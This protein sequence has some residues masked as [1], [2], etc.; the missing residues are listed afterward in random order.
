MRI[1]SIVSLGMLGMGCMLQPALAA[2][3]KVDNVSSLHAALDKARVDKRITRIELATGTYSLPAPIVFDEGLSGT[4]AMPFV[5]APVRGAHPVLSGAEN[6]PSLSWEAGKG[7]VW[8]ARV[9]D[10]DFQRLWLGT[11]ML[12]RARY[13][14][15]DPAIRTFGGVAADATSKE[16]V[17]SWR[18]PA[19]AVLHALHGGRW[20][21]VHVP[22]LGKNPDG[23]LRFGAQ[24]ANNRIAPPSGNARFVENILEEL[25]APG[26]WFHDRSGGW[27]YYKPLD[28][29]RPPSLGFR[30]GRLE[31]LVR[32]EG[33]RAP[34]NNIRIEGLA[35]RDTEPTFL[36]ATEPLLRS[37]WKFYRAGAVTIE[38]ASS[39]KVSNAD[40]SELGG[41]AVVVSGRASQVRIAGN[42]IHAIG[43]TAIA[44]VGRPEAVRSPLFEYQEQLA[45]SAIDRTPG[46]KS[47]QY[48]RDS[49][50]E[51]NLIHDI[52]LVD[53]QAAGVEIAMAARI[54]ID[55]NSIYQVP[56]AGIN[57]GDGSWGGHQITYND[58]FDTVLETGDHGAFNS[59]GRDRYWHPDRKEM[60]SR[61]AA[62]PSLAL[63][64]AIEPIVMRRNRFKCD[65]GWDV[66][67]DDGA[68]NYIIEENLMLSGGLKLREGFQRVVR[69]NILVN[70]S[71]HPHVWFANSADVFENNIVMAAHQPIGI[72]TWGKSVDR[73]LFANAADL[74]QA[75]AAGTDA[76]S[77]AGAL[78]FANPA[79]GDFR[80][81]KGSPAF[82]L[83]F[84]NFPMDQFGV[85][86]ARLKALAKQPAFPEP[87][88]QLAAGVQEKPRT[89]LGLTIKS[90]ETLGEQSAA[91]LLSKEGV[92][93]LAVEAASYGDKAGLLPRD[94]VIGIGNDPEAP[95]QLYPTAAALV[96]A[97]QARRWQSYVDLIVVRDQKRRAVKLQVQ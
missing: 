82:A 46:P 84:V 61:T 67:L 79:Q 64:D 44:F 28:G 86:P 23:S 3:I 63:L 62:E 68:T 35:F 77:V 93:V 29:K 89:F 38:N 85:R 66:D 16:R 55:H 31:T 13:P 80:V 1:V 33:K 34:A 94:V 92:L 19:G 73:N 56:R 70:G 41:N 17:A 20:G 96:S 78:Q 49:V 15:H 69:N 4:Q 74:A 91:G 52:G 45:L 42:H 32:I 6:L 76:N 54:S 57:V 60:D 27:L 95:A 59:W 5:M 18:D 90:I 14:N 37:D 88:L 39:V 97:L 50:A 75:R 71:F 87:E 2:T 21:G 83:G 51:D 58:V 22:I 81:G 12:V 9:K 30:A 43:G 8:R 26:E 65:H 10:R 53:K 72:N 40:F 24:T 11:S 25:D 47:D 7:G 48:P 36:K